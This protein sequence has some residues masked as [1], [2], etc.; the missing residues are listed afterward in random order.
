[1]GLLQDMAARILGHCTSVDVAWR[2]GANTRLLSAKRVDGTLAFFTDEDTARNYVKQVRGVAS[3]FEHY[4]IFAPDSL[5]RRVSGSVGGAK[6]GQTLVAY[7]DGSFV[8]A[9]SNHVA[10]Y[11][12]FCQCG[13]KA[14]EY[15]NTVL[16]NAMTFGSMGGEFAGA[17]VAVKVALW[18]GYDKVEIHHDFDGV[19]AFAK[20]STCRPKTSSKMYWLYEQ[21]KAFLEC[22]SN[23]I[24]IEFVKVKAHALDIGNEHANFLASTHAKRYAASLKSKNLNKIAKTGSAVSENLPDGFVPIFR[25]T[26]QAEKGQREITDGAIRNIARKMNAENSVDGCLMAE[27]TF[28]SSDL[29]EV[30]CLSDDEKTYMRFILSGARGNKTISNKMQCPAEKVSYLRKCCG[31]KMGLAQDE[32]HDDGII[33]KIV[34]HMYTDAKLSPLSEEE[35]KAISDSIPKTNKAKLEAKKARMQAKNEEKKNK[36]AS[37]GLVLPARGASDEEKAAFNLAVRAALAA[38]KSEEGQSQERHG[39]DATAYEQMQIRFDEGVHI[40]CIL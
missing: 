13:E 29:E 25:P 26:K 20:G 37:L 39:S 2:V 23:K 19:A 3:K 27:R 33:R 4:D 16:D 5:V 28:M 24:E 32:M 11:G 35:A 1:M 18:C 38:E 22:V 21:Y 9:G 40:S 17:V 14:A 10:G 6:K 15:A 31:T 36:L 30:L 12:V 8:H 34:A 7:T